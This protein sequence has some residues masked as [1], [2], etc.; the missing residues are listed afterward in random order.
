[1]LL[2]GPAL[3]LAGCALFAPHVQHPNLSVV[4]VEVA[5][6]QLLEQRFRVRVRVQNPNDRA[7]PVRGLS[8]TMELAGEDFGYGES[9]NAFTVPPLGEAEFDTFVTTHLATT[10]FRI[11]PRLKDSARPL[12]YRVV[13]KVA[14]DLVLL[15]SIPFDQRGTIGSS[16]PP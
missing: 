7:L 2:A 16:R 1:M 8:F 11:L 9:A 10:L 4:G 6:A 5:D 13:G 14:T 3:G 15:R 12:E